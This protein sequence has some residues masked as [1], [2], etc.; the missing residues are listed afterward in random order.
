MCYATC[1]LLVIGSQ[2]G[3]LTLDLSFGHNLC[4]KCLNGSFQTSRFKKLFNSMDF[5]PCNHLLKIRKSIG[6]PTLKMRYHLGVWGF[7]PSHFLTFP[8]TWF[9]TLELHSW[10]APL[11]AFA[12]VTS[13]RIG[14][15]HKVYLVWMGR[16]HSDVVN[17]ANDEHYR[18]VHVQWWLPFKKGAH[19]DAYLY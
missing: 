10:P 2:I 4:F 19:N 15:W 7:I 17:N 8:W 11:Q 12:L 3:N 18:M 9:V 16:T 14:L 6:I 1:T 13:P 5:D